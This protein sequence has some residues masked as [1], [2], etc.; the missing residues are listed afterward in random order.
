VVATGTAVL[1]LVSVGGA[2]R[3]GSIAGRHRG[4]EVAIAAT[5]HRLVAQAPGSHDTHDL[6]ALGD[7]DAA[8]GDAD[9]AMTRWEN[10]T[11]WLV[12][13]VLVVT[14][15]VALLVALQAHE[16]GA[17][18]TGTLFAVLSYLLVLQGPAVRCARQITRTAPLLVSARELGRLVVPPE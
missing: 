4:R 6:A 14:C 3:V 15:A 11:T 1:C 2:R 7:L 5:V 17:F 18:G 12:H 9:V 8:S 16:S 10:L 13:I